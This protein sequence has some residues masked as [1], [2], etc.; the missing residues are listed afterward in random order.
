MMRKLFVAVLASGGFA[1]AATPAVA[2]PEHQHC[3]TTPNGESHEIARGVQEHAPHDTAFHNFH[4]HVHTGQPSES[5]PNQIRG[6]PVG[7][8]C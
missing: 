8:E 5:N 3:L 6:V 4:K 2:V 7:A 1:L